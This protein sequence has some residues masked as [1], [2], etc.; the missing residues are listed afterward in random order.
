LLD[1]EEG[2]TAS[3]EK[4][5]NQDPIQLAWMVNQVA[6][7]ARAR[8]LAKQPPSPSTKVDGVASFIVFQF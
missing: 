5:A 2:W 6:Q 7:P 1:G 4:H 3:K 8:D